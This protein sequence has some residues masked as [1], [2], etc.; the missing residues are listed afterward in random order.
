MNDQIK[1]HI[2]SQRVLS[3]GPS[4]PVELWY[5]TLK[6]PRC[7]QQL[8]S[9]LNSAVQGFYGGFDFLGMID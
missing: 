6:A 1:R 8:G 5:A 9:P 7:V 2:E 3:I 4:A